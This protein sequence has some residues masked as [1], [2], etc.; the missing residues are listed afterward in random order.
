MA[1]RFT[2]LCGLTIAFAA[3]ASSP[4]LADLPSPYGLLALAVDAVR[5]ATSEKESVYLRAVSRTLD[6]S[7]ISLPGAARLI[8]GDGFAIM[9]QAE[10]GQA[11]LLIRPVAAGVQGLGFIKAPEAVATRTSAGELEIAVLRRPL[12]EEIENHNVFA[13]E[14]EIEGISGPQASAISQARGPFHAVEEAVDAA[15]SEKGLAPPENF[16]F[17]RVG[18]AVEV[19]AAL[20]VVQKLWLDLSRIDTAIVPDLVQAARAAIEREAHAAPASRSMQGC[21]FFFDARGDLGAQGPP[22]I[23][24]RRRSSPA[25]GKRAKPAQNTQQNN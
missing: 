6:T 11:V 9:G 22:L 17:S 4:A 20:V 12:R 1:N 23:A 3:L 18:E 19:G 15:L 2:Q 25:L 24:K 10:D 7:L 5:S 16:R 13:P 21:R 14:A 8:A